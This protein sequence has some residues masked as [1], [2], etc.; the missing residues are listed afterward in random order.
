V[1]TTFYLRTQ[2][3]WPVLIAHGVLD[4]VALANA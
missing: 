2:R 1:F 4:F 3:L